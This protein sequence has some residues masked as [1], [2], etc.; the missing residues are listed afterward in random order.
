M[1]K[2]KNENIIG[3][4]PRMFEVYK[5]IGKAAGN[6]AS[7][8]IQGETGTGKELVA[9]AIH[10]HGTLRKGPFVVVDCIGLPEGLLDLELFGH[11]NGVLTKPT[12]P[13]IG[14]LELAKRGTLFFDEIGN[15]S[16]II[17]TKLLRALEEKKI[18]RVGGTESI[19]VDGRIIAATHQD[20][21]KAV[22]E[23]SFR[24]NLYYRLN[25]VLINLPPLR[26]RKDDIPL[27]VEHFLRRY[28]SESEGKLKYVPLETLDLLMRYNWPGNVRELENVIER[29]VVMGTG[30]A[31]LTQDLPLEIQKN[32]D[33]PHPIISSGR[34]SLN[35]G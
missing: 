12:A 4:N 35:F 26:E 34:T 7:V 27:L 10:F 32:S 3:K 28:S 33:I 31:I 13:R 9:R 20:L 16:L 1:D 21:E 17:Q 24:E 30:D 5:A 23:D 14:K 15:L 6:K 22:R 2:S 19:K 18:E 25:V 8:L 11:E 29:A